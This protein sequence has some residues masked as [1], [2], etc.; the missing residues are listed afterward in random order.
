M[1]LRSFVFSNIQDFKN[2]IEVFNGRSCAGTLTEDS[3]GELLE[4][5]D[6]FQRFLESINSKTFVK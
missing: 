1:C 5:S 2:F 6:E 3:F 4:R